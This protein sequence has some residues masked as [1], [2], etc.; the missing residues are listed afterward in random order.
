MKKITP[1]ALIVFSSAPEAAGD[2][3]FFCLQAEVIS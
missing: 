3:D 1:R 2:A